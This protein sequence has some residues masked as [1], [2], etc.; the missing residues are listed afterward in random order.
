MLKRRWFMRK[1]VRTHRRP[2][3]MAGR[4]MVFAFVCVSLFHAT[5]A[6]AAFNSSPSSP[7]MIVSSATLAAPTSPA[8]STVNC[9]VLGSTKVKLTW[10]ATTSGWADG[11]QIFRSTTN[12]G[13]YSSVGTVSGQATTTFTDSSVS[14]STT[15][16]YVIQATK[17]NWRSPNSTQV[18]F[19]TPTAL[20]V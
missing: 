14:F 4:I 2:A 16:Y 18:T 19:T 12:G 6:F 11:Y 3:R 5:S 17:N 7:T 15:Y 10:T 8:A 20:C 1:R 13:P 9:V